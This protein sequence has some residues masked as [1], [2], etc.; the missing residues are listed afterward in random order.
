MEAAEPGS[1]F[2]FT[3]TTHRQW[4]DIVQTAFEACA[5][6]GL[7]GG[8]LGEA[9]VGAGAGA[10]SGRAGGFVFPRVQGKSGNQLVMVKNAP[11]SSD[12]AAS[13]PP[14]TSPS[15]E[16]AAWLSAKEREQ[17]LLFKRDS[18]MHKARVA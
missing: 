4:P 3:E 10:G 15:L 8:R 1:L 5:V 2:V 14:A 16:D 17:L 12:S 11:A 18:E 13:D 6:K 7:V 9:G